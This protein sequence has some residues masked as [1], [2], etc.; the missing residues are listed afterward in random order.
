MLAIVLSGGGAKGAYQAGVWKALKH[1]KI[2][3]DIVTG[4]SIGAINGM[5]M[6]QNDYYN[7]MRLWKNINY[8]ILYDDFEYVAD[9]VDMFKKY[10]QKMLTGGLDTS[11]IEKL[12]NSNYNSKKLYNSKIAYGIMSYNATT[13]KA[14]TSTTRNT[15]PNILKKYILASAT[16]FPAFKPTKI[17][18]DTYIDGGYYDNMP[19]NLA[20]DLGADEIIAVDLGALGFK[21]RIKTKDVKVTLIKPRK[22]LDPFFMFEPNSARR[23]I[24]LGYNDTMKTFG[25]LDGDLYTFKKGTINTIGNKYKKKMIDIATYYDDMS[26]VKKLNKNML[27]VVEESLDILEL[28]MD[29]IYN[30]AS[31]NSEF[32]KRISKIEDINL[33]DFNIEQIKK[34]FDKKSITKSFYTKIKKRDKISNILINIFNKEFVTA[35][36][37]V[38][39]GS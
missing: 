38:A 11:K 33:N 23:M 29:R 31:I 6:A 30:I 35:I 9:N 7:A 2:K 18:V 26:T 37:L 21:K 12:I 27:E 28:R 4:T 17:G 19:L 16:C 5:M 15:R 14:V 24:N 20:I 39:I 13:K 34:I 10:V 3:Y 1:L 32:I 22:K 8:K 25:K 36:Y